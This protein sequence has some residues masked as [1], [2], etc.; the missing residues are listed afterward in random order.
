MVVEAVSLGAGL[1]VVAP[2]KGVEAVVALRRANTR[3]GARKHGSRTWLAIL[4]R[5]RP[6]FSHAPTELKGVAPGFF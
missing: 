2:P 1:F 4:L 3:K 5:F 6:T